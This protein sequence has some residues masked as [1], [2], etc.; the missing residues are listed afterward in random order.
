VPAATTKLLPSHRVRQATREV[1]EKRKSDAL[2]CVCN[3]EEDRK[4]TENLSKTVSEIEVTAYIIKINVVVP[5]VLSRGC[6]S[7]RDYCKLDCFV[8]RIQRHFNVHFA[9]RKKQKNGCLPKFPTLPSVNGV[10]P[11]GPRI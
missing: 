1:K 3:L 2:E 11:K 4:R 8:R 6:G 5:K 9:E 10:P 7:K